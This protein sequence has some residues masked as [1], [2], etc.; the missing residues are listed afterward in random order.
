MA[1]SVNRKYWDVVPPENFIDRSFIRHNY[2][3]MGL[4]IMLG[5]KIE[6]K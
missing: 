2:Q 3:V 5:R 6:V 4:L 1:S